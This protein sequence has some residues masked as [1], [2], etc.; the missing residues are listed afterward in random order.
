MPKQ[1]QHVTQQAELSADPTTPPSGYQV[2][3][4]KTDGKYYARNSAGTVTEITNTAGGGLS[5]GDKGDIRV[6]GSGTVLTMDSWGKILA[7]QIFKL[8]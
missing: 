2:L 8:R 6:S 1:S 5:D 3:Y 4:A 7:Q